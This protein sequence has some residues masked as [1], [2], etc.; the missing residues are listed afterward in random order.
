MVYSRAP[1]QGPG[2]GMVGSSDSAWKQI[3]RTDPYFGVLTDD[4][5]RNA[6]QAGPERDEF[7]NSG[8][9]HIEHIFTAVRELVP[10]FAPRSAVDFGCGVARLVLPL[11]RAVPKVV[12][13][14]VSPAMLAEARRNCESEGVTNVTFCESPTELS[15]QVDFV[16]SYIVFQHIPVNRGVELA[17][18]LLEHLADGG[19]GALHFTYATPQGRLRRIVQKMYRWVPGAYAATNLLLGRRNKHP[20]MQMN[21]YSLNELFTLLQKHGCHRVHAYFSDH[22]GTLGAMLIF[23]KQPLPPL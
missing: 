19:V 3:G 17:K 18:V 13:I 8:A 1:L 23:Q 4:R 22:G 9:H 12:G 7:F 16:H 11:A 6:S 15:G 21:A 14:D 10:G 2:D 20:L 5:F